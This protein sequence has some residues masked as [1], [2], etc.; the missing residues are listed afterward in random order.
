[1]PQVN[2]R[3]GARRND[4]RINQGHIMVSR[5]SIYGILGMAGLVAGMAPARAAIVTYTFTGINIGGNYDDD[6]DH[7]GLFGTPA[8]LDGRAFK[9][10]YRMDTTLGLEVD[11]ADGSSA[12]T[13]H[14]YR[15]Q[16]QPTDAESTP[17]I[18]AT[19]TI[20]GHSYHFDGSFS[21]LNDYIAD[22]SSQVE[23]L[24][25]FGYFT[26]LKLAAR[27][28]PDINATVDMLSRSVNHVI[29]LGYT[30]GYTIDF[31]NGAGRDPAFYSNGGFTIRTNSN[32]Q[33][34]FSHSALRADRL[35]VTVSNGI[36]GGV[37][38]PMEWAMLAMG[39]GL[40]GSA[41]RRRS[42]STPRSA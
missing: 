23:T 40:V 22:S 17:A 36:A 6:Y 41:L 10:V 42:A 12:T 30:Q 8:N 16:S 3:S 7:L 4:G 37:P 26:D 35:V 20:D 1:L 14:T 24:N 25:A 33:Y 15:R 34:A 11:F 2:V 29:P 39:F 9:L 5:I 32:D 27:N 19:L 28:G 31:V 13:R 38:E 21:P 18:K